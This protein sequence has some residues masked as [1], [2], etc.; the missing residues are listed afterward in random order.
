MREGE[1]DRERGRRGRELAEADETHPSD[2]FINDR[3]MCQMSSTRPV[4]TELVSSEGK[5][6]KG[7][8]GGAGEERRRTG[9]L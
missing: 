7:R 9:R 1:R 3:N 4:V 5:G 8:Q 2:K 6:D